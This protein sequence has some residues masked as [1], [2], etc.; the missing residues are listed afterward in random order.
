MSATG[1]WETLLVLRCV[2]EYNAGRR[3]SAV[4]LRKG[5]AAKGATRVLFS[6]ADHPGSARPSSLGRECAPDRMASEQLGQGT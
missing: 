6:V 1:G 3:M 4:R 2:F 5:Y